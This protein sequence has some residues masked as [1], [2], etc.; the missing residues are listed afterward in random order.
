MRLA[1]IGDEEFPH[2]IVLNARD[3]LTA[4]ASM[5]CRVATC[6]P[7][8]GQGMAHGPEEQVRPPVGLELGFERGDVVGGEYPV[9]ADGALR[10]PYDGVGARPPSRSYRGSSLSFPSR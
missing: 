9:V 3:R 2:G 1:G 6:T 4:I 7:A 5:S 8:F 10:A